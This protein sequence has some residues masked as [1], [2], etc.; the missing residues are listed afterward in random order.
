MRMNL[1]LPAMALLIAGTS[2]ASAVFSI[3]PDW[4]YEIGGPSYML[5]CIET[6]LLNE[7]EYPDIAVGDGYSGKITVG[8]YT[9]LLRTETVSVS[10]R[11]IRI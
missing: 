2:Q 11:C 4:L 5:C 1:L 9:L 8:C 6:F 3:E 7:D 10:R